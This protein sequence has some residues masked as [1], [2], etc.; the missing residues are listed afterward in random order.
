RRWSSPRRR[1]PK[2]RRFMKSGSLSGIQQAGDDT[3]DPLP[4]PG[5]RGELLLSGAG[6]R[7]VLRATVAL[8]DSPP[9]ADP[10]ALLESEESG[11][12]RSLVHPQHLVGDLLESSGNPVAVQRSQSLQ[13]LEHHEV[14]GSLEHFGLVVS[15]GH[16]SAASCSCWKSTGEYFC[17]C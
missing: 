15:V 17:F 12:E 16:A 9:G 8:G 4:V 10:A 11:V 7:I 5:F 2:K 6:E 1:A 3:G 13:R 14:Q